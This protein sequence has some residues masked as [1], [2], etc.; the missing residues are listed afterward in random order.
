MP[1]SRRSSTSSIATHDDGEEQP[2]FPI[3][4]ILDPQ[5]P[6]ATYSAQLKQN[7][8]WASMRDGKCLP[9]A[10]RDYEP[11]PSPCSSEDD[12][13]YCTDAPGS[14]PAST[15]VLVLKQ[16]RDHERFTLGSATTNHV[17]LRHP[18]TVIEDSCFINLLHAQLYLDPDSETLRL[19]NSSTSTFTVSPITTCEPDQDISPQQDIKLACGIWRVGLGQGLD[20]NITIVPIHVELPRNYWAPILGGVSSRPKKKPPLQ[21]PQ[22]LPPRKRQVVGVENSDTQGDRRTIPRPNRAD[23]SSPELKSLRR[24]LAY[25]EYSQPIDVSSRGRPEDSQ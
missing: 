22:S 4:A 1:T 8:P 24:K 5:S 11:L 3:R 17:L 2:D 18:D 20:F 10:T 16:S 25:A 23:T 21:R 15:T 7:L 13:E 6:S 9:S 19:F 12:D 14:P